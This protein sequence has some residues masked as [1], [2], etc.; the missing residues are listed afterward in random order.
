MSLSTE[1]LR[2]IF[3]YCD[4]KLIRKIAISNNSKIGEIAGFHGKNGYFYASVDDK[5]YPLHRLI[6]IWHGK[7]E[8]GLDH[9]NN[10]PSDNRIE[11]LRPASH[12]QNMWNKRIAKNNSTGVKGVIWKK[13][14]Q[15]Y[16]VRIGVNGKRIH[17]G[18]FVDLEL[19]ELVAVEARAKYH[20]Q[21]AN[22]S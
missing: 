20:G 7:E 4:G 6:W 21:F 15:K 19:A 14:K 8:C 3:D 22:H 2:Q 11:N 1:R 9:I 13:D 18:D 10:D 5:T 17:I 16:R 12:S